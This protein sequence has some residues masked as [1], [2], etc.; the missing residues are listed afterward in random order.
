M[1]R[2]REYTST[3]YACAYGW[4]LPG[5]ISNVQSKN[6]TV[7]RQSRRLSNHIERVATA[8]QSSLPVHP[9]ETRPPSTTTPLCPSAL[10]DATTVALCQMEKRRT[11]PNTETPRRD[12][13]TKECVIH[14]ANKVHTWADLPGEWQSCK[15]SAWRKYQSMYVN[16]C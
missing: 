2:A 15:Y 11:L 10:L 8:R 5:Y 6:A 12:L 9:E 16:P 13:K 7:R 4:R 3:K 1:A 14:L